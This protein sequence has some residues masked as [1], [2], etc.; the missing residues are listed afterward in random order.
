VTLGIVIQ[1]YVYIYVYIHITFSYLTC[2]VSGHVHSLA[3]VNRAI[4][5]MSLQVSLLY[6]FL[7]SLGYMPRSGTAGFMAVLVVVF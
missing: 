1:T 3:V 4:K 6:P 5:N 2:R 7:H